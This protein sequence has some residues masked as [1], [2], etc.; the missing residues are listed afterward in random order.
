MK[1]HTASGLGF[2]VAAM[3]SAVA[4]GSESGPPADEETTAVEQAMNVPA[5]V[6]PAT[7]QLVAADHFQ[8]SGGELRVTYVP[9]VETRLPVFVYQDADQ[10]QTFSGN[11]IQTTATDAGT[12]VSVYVRHTID[13][14][15]T[16]LSVLIPRVE[17]PENASVPVETQ[18]ITAVHRFSVAPVSSGGQLDLYSFT[19]LQGMASRSFRE[20]SS[21]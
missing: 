1:L 21:P 15:A 4:C 11:D 19:P 3:L 7:Q 20:T 17:L 8:L 10:K 5:P 6:G 9:A 2:V 16:T 18:A 14:G 12:L 13:A